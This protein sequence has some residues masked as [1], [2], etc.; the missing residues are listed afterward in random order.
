MDGSQPP[1]LALI[2]NALVRPQILCQRSAVPPAASKASPSPSRR[3][4][5]ETNHVVS[6]CVTKATMDDLL[7]LS[8]RFE[9]F[10]NLVCK[11]PPNTLSRSTFIDLKFVDAVERSVGR[12]YRMFALV[13]KLLLCVPCIQA[14]HPNDQRWNYRK[15][16]NIR[17][18]VHDGPRCQTWDMIYVAKLK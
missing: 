17:K 8:V 3:L 6:V 15:I 2:T 14:I 9:T 5:L 12:A 10:P 1:T 7:V 18:R 13:N 16:E 4:N 11:Y